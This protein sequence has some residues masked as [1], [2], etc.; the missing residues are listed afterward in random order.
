[1]N[2]AQTERRLAELEARL[3]AVELR[4]AQDDANRTEEAERERRQVLRKSLAASRHPLDLRN[5]DPDDLARWTREVD[6]ATCG[7]RAA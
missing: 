1:M 2:A 3:A 5:A 4:L 7:R 6:R